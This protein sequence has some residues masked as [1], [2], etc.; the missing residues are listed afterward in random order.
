MKRFLTIL[1]AVLALPALA[2]TSQPVVVVSGALKVIPAGNALQI[3]SM[4]GSGARCVQADATGKL[5]VAASAC[6]TGGSGSVTSVNVSGGSTGLTT[7]GGPVTT[8]GTITLGGTL[9]VANGGTG[10]TTLTG[11]VKGSGTSA[12]TASATVPG[13]DVSGNIAGN[14][15]NV[16]GTVAVANGGTGSTTAGGA[17]TSLGVAIG[18]DVQAYSANLGAYAGA[19]T[20]SAFTLG[21]VDSADAAAWRS[22]IGAGT[23]STTGTVTSV[24]ASGG[25]T[26]LSFSGGPITSSGTLTLGGTLAVANGGTGVTTST[27]T[28]STVRATQPQF[29]NTIGVG[30]AAS[31]SG[32]GVSFPAS[33]SASSDANTLDDY[34]EGTWTPTVTTTSGSLTSYTASGHYTKIGRQVYAT[35]EANIT[36]NGTGAGAVVVTLPFSAS[37]NAIWVGAGRENAMTGNMLQAIVFAGAPNIIVQTYNNAYPAVTGATIL[38]SVSYFI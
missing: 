11:Y 6:A 18:S 25:T 23:S 8:T 38:I 5:T 37:P 14:A 21:I 1:A 34:E 24:N 29:T 26:G 32:S 17:R 28:S 36:N 19:D 33:Q 22:A 35:V 27:G 9:G 30:A 31:G 7:T 20:P 3:P 12:L 15:A 2:Q 16:T 13:A 10:A 4:A